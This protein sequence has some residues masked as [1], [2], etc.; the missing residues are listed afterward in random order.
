MRR[1]RWL[2]KHWQAWMLTLVSIYILTCCGCKSTPIPVETDP[3]QKQRALRELTVGGTCELAGYTAVRVEGYGL[4]CNLP[5][6]GSSECP[7]IQ[8]EFLLHHLRTLN[9][10]GLIPK[11]YEFLTAEQILDSVT[12]AAVKV[13]GLVPPGAP[14]GEIFDVEVVALPQT[15]TTSLQGGWLLPTDLQVI[16]TGDSGALAG[17]PTAQAA[18]P[19]FINPFPISTRQGTKSDPR[20]GVV[21]G[22]GLSL[23]DRSLLLKILQPDTRIADLIQ[24]RINTRFSQT[25]GPKIADATRSSVQITI[26][27]EFRP[28]YRHFVELL[29]AL[30]LEERPGHRDMRLKE[31]NTLASLPNADYASIAL[32]WEAI[33][34]ESL[35]HLVPLYK[36]PTDKR[37]FY[38]ARTALNLG[39]LSA[40]DA[41]IAIAKNDTHP[42][43]LLAAESLGVIGQDPRAIQARSALAELLNRPNGRLRLLAYDGLRKAHDGRIRVVPLS[44]DFALELVDSTAENMVCIWATSEPRIVLFGQDWRCPGNIF[45]D[46][47]NRVMLNVKSGEAEF[48]ISRPAPSGKGIFYTK[49]PLFVPDL[50]ATLAK[51][52]AA[53]EEKMSPLPGLTFSEA[54]GILYQLCN[55]QKV[56]PAIFYLHRVP[57]DLTG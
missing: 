3:N 36:N 14:K 32:S 53:P 6:T 4:V 43:Q 56:I 55:H 38:A 23:K 42:C 29:M 12:T 34:K 13:S 21:L 57:E 28:K 49:C 52:I 8:R 19:V 31:L 45:F 30:D 2:K 48:S 39:D 1:Y 47:E 16:I 46:W 15:Q 41:M 26:P 24:R 40:L 44:G 50:I 51:P 27:S 20:K 9:S 33:G 37:S 10:N 35:R 7:P 25:G 5:G 22:G 18:G 11:R 17:R 54:V